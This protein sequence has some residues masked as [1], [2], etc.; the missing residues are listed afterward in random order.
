MTQPETTETPSSDGS[1]TGGST[2]GGPSTDGPGS[3]SSGGG[4]TRGVAAIVCFVLAAVLTA[5]ATVAFWAQRTVLDTG[6]F[7]GTIEPLAESPEVQDA[8]A[9]V[10]VAALQ[11]RVD[12]EALLEEAFAGVT[13]TRPR[14]DALVPPLA[15][16]VDGLIEREVREYVA[17][18]DF[19]TVWVTSAARA[20]TAA[21]LV[22]EGREEG[23]AVALVGEDLVVDV[24]AVVEAVRQRLVDR[25]FV[26][27]EGVTVP[28]ADR[29]IVVATAPRL[30]TARSAYAVAAPLALWLLPVTLAL[31]A[32][33]VLLARRRARM[34]LAVGVS[35]VVNAAV[36]GVALAIARPLTT[37]EFSGTAF[38]DAGDEIY[39]VLTASLQRGWYVMAASGVILVMAGWWAGRSR[40][41]RV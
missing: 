40:S 5:P 32:A 36:I 14:L 41:A 31:Y 29:Q 6:Q 38:A 16:A 2:T 13:D 15:A 28:A 3:D 20:Q 11:E 30:A 21:V 1:N 24:G 4:R 12:V 37:R 35:L 23:G 17:S 22:L 10:A 8:V 39:A 9:T 33:A 25:G 26:S 7:A 18:D 19:G 27:L 34:T